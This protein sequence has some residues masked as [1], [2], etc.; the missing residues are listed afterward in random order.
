[1]VYTDLTSELGSLEFPVQ[2]QS[3]ITSYPQE[4]QF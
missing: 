2:S 1:M 3:H 4:E